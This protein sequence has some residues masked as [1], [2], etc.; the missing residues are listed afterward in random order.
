MVRA[1]RFET[2]GFDSCLIRAAD[3]PFFIAV[4]NEASGNERRRRFSLAHEIGHAVLPGHRL[5]AHA[6]EIN[7][8]A[9]TAQ[10]EPRAATDHEV[11]SAAERE[12][13]AFAAALLLPARALQD[14]AAVELEPEALD[15]LAD[16]YMISYTALV[17]NLIPLSPARAAAFYCRDGENVFWKW[18]RSLDVH[19]RKRGRL[20]RASL[21][22]ALLRQG[23]ARPGDTLRGEVPPEAW[24]ETDSWH[25]EG[26]VDD[27]DGG[28]GGQVVYEAS[29]LVS[30][31]IVVTVVEIREDG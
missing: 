4:I 8:V 19:V 25:T 31:G 18:S 29:R 21:A 5:L 28:H 15:R 14:D 3:L 10:R 16:K 27:S 24:F 1:Q 13:D 2:P 30:P 23:G 26:G 22:Y 17:F 7:E 6:C 20:D 12:A 9:P 11:V